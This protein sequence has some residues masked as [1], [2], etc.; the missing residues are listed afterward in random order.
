MNIDLNMGLVKGRVYG[1]ATANDDR[2]H[3]IA[4][5]NAAL[6]VS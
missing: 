5:S 2:G 6:R 4:M 3:V 1:D